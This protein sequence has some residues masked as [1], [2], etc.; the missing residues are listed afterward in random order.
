[1]ES[2]ARSSSSG[3]QQQLSLVEQ[4]QQQQCAT[5]AGMVREQ[6]LQRASGTPSYEECVDWLLDV[7]PLDVVNGGPPITSDRAL[8]W[9]DCDS[10]P[11]L[12]RAR[13]DEVA[14]YSIAEMH[15]MNGQ[16]MNLLARMQRPIPSPV[17]HQVA[18]ELYG[19]RWHIDE[20][21]DLT[22]INYVLF[23]R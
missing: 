2:G 4:Q 23:A 19:M 16:L 14:L 15:Q 9:W 3:E 17:A 10:D 5:L 6:L 20:G 7:I 13:E 22:A 1:M 12:C 11:L 21:D 8:V 18:A